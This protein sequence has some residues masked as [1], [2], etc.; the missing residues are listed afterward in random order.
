MNHLKI[1]IDVDGV[2]ADFNTNYRHELHK[3]SPVRFPEISDTFPN[4]WHWDKAAGLSSETIASAWD[5]IKTSESFW[6][7][8]PPYNGTE[9]FLFSLFVRPE[10]DVYFITNRLGA[11]V[12]HQ[13]E[14]WLTRYGYD[15]P[16]V[17][18]TA[19]K[20]GA[21]KVLGLDFY[22][23]DKTENCSDV[24]FAS[25]STKIYMLAQ[26]WNI[27]IA[28]IPR[29]ASVRDFYDNILTE[30]NLGQANQ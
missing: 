30:L 11:G 27:R 24:Y 7:E 13:T 9:I 18:I 6:A 16:T 25:P 20:G 29:I 8:L 21:A 3:V 12:K 22:I 2:L 19:D 17:L 28:G 5:S 4:T 1:G 23:D 15:S 10:L 14:E 26:P